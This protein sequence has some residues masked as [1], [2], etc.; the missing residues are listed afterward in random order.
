MSMEFK[1]PEPTLLSHYSSASLVV[2]VG[3]HRQA[4]KYVSIHFLVVQVKS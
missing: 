4:I 2:A 3:N 1:T